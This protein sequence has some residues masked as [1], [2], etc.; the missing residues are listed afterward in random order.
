[1]SSREQVNGADRFSASA[2]HIVDYLNAHTPISDW[3]VSRVAGG[4]QVHV[5]VHHESLIGVGDRHAWTDTFCR[6]MV[7]GASHIVPDSQADPDYSDHPDADVVRSYAGYPITDD[8]GSTFGVLCGVGREPLS[9]PSAVDEDL[10]SLMS[11]LLSTQLVMSRAIDRDRRAVEIAEALAN[12]D[13]LTGLVNRRGWDLLVTDAQERVDAF[14]DPVA[15]AVI[16]LDGLKAVNDSAGHDAGDDLL[17]RAALALLSA[18][19][20]DDRVAR[21]GGDEFA[22]LS[23]NVAASDLPMHFTRFVDAMREHGVMGSLGFSLTAPGAMSLTDA[24]I[25]ADADMYAA[26]Q[27]RRGA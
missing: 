9:T 2:Q 21:Y 17:R 18:A 16:D 1:V 26:K 11:E 15:V 5:H 4:E 14:G 19:G 27:S 20:P 10:I 22:I 12:T 8:D 24:F 6:R 13:A 7:N 3:S 23:N 25:Q